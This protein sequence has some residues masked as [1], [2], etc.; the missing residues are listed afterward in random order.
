[1]IYINIKDKENCHPSKFFEQNPIFQSSLYVILVVIPEEQ[2]MLMAKQISRYHL[3]DVTWLIVTPKECM[4]LCEKYDFF[5]KLVVMQITM[6]GNKDDVF[7]SP[8]NWE[9]LQITHEPK[10]DPFD[11][12]FVE[13]INR[14]IDQVLYNFPN[15]TRSYKKRITELLLDFVS[16]GM[17]QMQLDHKK[18]LGN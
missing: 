12:Q 8:H 9:M 10:E 1:M 13:T 7:F 6:T 3:D 5:Y 4:E 17:L 15:E 16:S 18:V 2:K 11:E 14:L